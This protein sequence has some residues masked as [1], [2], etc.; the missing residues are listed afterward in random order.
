[1][2]WFK[3]KRL[4][5]RICDIQNCF[6]NNLTTVSPAEK[7]VKRAQSN[8]AT[9]KT[10]AS[11]PGRKMIQRFLKELNGKLTTE[12]NTNKI[13]DFDN[14]LEFF[15]DNGHAKIS[16]HNTLSIFNSE[17]TMNYTLRDEKY[18]KN[19][20][21]GTLSESSTTTDI[22]QLILTETIRFNTKFKSDIKW[23]KS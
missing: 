11:E 13:Y 1:M 8:Y 7:A 15:V 9:V 10:I 4:D 2:I 20:L 22:V 5:I 16:I 19:T 12:L 14:L 23:T 3:R 21:K 17:H 6:K 18:P